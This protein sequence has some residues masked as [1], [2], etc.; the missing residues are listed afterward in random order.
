MTQMRAALSAEFL[1]IRRSR[2]PWIACAA[3]CIGPVMGAVFVVVLRTPGLIA[4]NPALAA[5]ATMTG[6]SPDWTGFLGLVAQVI[7][8]GGPIVFGFV[9]SWCFGR[10]FSDGTAKDLLALPVSRT[11][12]VLA[13]M[14]AVA[15]WCFAV[16]CVVLVVSLITGSALGLQQWS[17]ALFLSACQDASNTA[18]MA[19]LL[20]PPVA[21]VASVARGYLAPLGFVVL[22]IVLAQ[23]LGALGRGALFPWAVPGLYSGLVPGSR[24]SLTLLSYLLLCV[25]A[26]GG[27]LGTIMWWRY[28]DQSG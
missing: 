22:M 19:V 24:D 21:L 20:C 10:E 25:V 1:K 16:A 8:V 5:K 15:L 2:V 7:G 18:V 26:L 4:D 9:A 28:A 17:S 13:K 11:K 12:I 27:T 14:I 6:F 3:L 23:I